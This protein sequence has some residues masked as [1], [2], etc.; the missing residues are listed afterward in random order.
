MMSSN[1][2]VQKTVARKGS[3]TSSLNTSECRVGR[4]LYPRWRR[5][6]EEK[7]EMQKLESRK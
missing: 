5:A 4:A 6:G 2:C 7:L 3:S 1:L